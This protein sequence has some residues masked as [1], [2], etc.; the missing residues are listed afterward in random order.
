MQTKRIIIITLLI[1]IVLNF[2]MPISLAENLADV[3]APNINIDSLK[4]QN[5]NLGKSMSTTDFNL[6]KELIK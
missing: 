1:S 5:S 6:D 2:L 3:E 4:K